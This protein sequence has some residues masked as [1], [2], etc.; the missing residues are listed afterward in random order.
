M[1][2]QIPTTEEIAGA[3]AEVRRAVYDRGRSNVGSILKMACA[4][5]FVEPADRLLTVALENMQDLVER[6]LLRTF[7]GVTHEQVMAAHRALLP[8]RG[9]KQQGE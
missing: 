2:N 5:D 1:A 8:P 4:T 3:I 9:P 6:I 7:P